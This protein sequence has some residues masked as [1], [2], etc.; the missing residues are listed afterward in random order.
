M[1]MI[2]AKTAPFA[3]ISAVVIIFVAASFA[4]NQPTDDLVSDNYQLDLD[5]ENDI[6]FVKLAG[7]DRPL[8]TKGVE[9]KYLQPLAEA[10]NQ[11][12]P[13]TTWLRSPCFVFTGWDKESEYYQ[14]EVRE[15]HGQDCEG[16]P[17]TSPL[18]KMFQINKSTSKIT[19]Y[20]VMDDKWREY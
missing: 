7:I 15:W 11:S 18:M 13:S 10:I 19:G 5:A 17:N 9:L 6:Q 8:K 3:I 20:D 1:K 12:D 16:D 4:Q 2:T 14:I